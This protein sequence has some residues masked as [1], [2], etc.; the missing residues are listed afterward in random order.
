MKQVALLAVVL[1]TLLGSGNSASADVITDWNER[2]VAAGY[3]ARLTPNVMSRQIAMV[4]IAM[5]E[6]LNAIEPRYTPYRARL[7]A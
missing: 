4:H 5:F 1:L 2:A 6:A 3:T 7:S